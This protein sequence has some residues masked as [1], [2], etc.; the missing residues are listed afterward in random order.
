MGILV[1]IKRLFIKPP[2]L[3][4]DEAALPEV[5]LVGAAYNEQDFIR[6]KIK[7]TFELDYPAG[8]LEI[9]FIT[10]GSSDATPAIIKEYPSIRLLHQPERKGKV[11]AM[12]RAVQ[13]VQSSLIIFCDANTLLNKSCVR[14][15]VKHYSDP[16]VGGVAGEKKSRRFLVERHD[17]R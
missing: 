14:E 12:N 4:V 17:A 6:E 8:K 5:A 16:K 11:A 9:I 3:N 13:Y 1:F 10:D 2:R 7:N 15:I